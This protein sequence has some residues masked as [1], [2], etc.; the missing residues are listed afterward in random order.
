MIIAITDHKRRRRLAQKLVDKH[1]SV[2][3]LF[4]IACLGLFERSVEQIKEEQINQMKGEN[5][6]SHKTRYRDER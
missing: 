6:F 4:T 5:S 2:F 3:F 1:E